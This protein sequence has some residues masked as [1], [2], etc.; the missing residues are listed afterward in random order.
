MKKQSKAI[1]DSSTRSQ[2]SEGIDIKSEPVFYTSKTNDSESH[3]NNTN[4]Y[5]KDNY[6]YRKFP[7]S[8]GR[9]NRQKQDAR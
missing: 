1:F 5:P 2:S 8:S 6:R 7:S 4:Q 3:K 9:N